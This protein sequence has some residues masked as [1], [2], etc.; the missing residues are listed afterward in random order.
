MKIR[1]GELLP[2]AKRRIKESRSKT[3]VTTGDFQQRLAEELFQV[4]RGSSATKYRSRVRERTWRELPASERGK[5]LA[6]VR[7]AMGKAKR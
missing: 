7:A 4:H 1:D 6:I 5:Y 2:L 3:D